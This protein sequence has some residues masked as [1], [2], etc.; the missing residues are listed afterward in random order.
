MVRLAPAGRHHAFEPLPHLSTKL[1]AHFPTACVHNFA[2]SDRPGQALFYHVVNAYGYS[3]LRKRTKERPGDQIEE[4]V[5]PVSTLDETLPNDQAVDLIKVD[6]EG[7]E[8]Q[9]FRGGRRTLA[10]CRPH[11]LFEHGIGG[12]NY[13]GTTPEMVYDF[14]VHELRYRIHAVDGSGPFSLAEFRATYQRNDRW[15]F[16]AQP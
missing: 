15:D 11:L 4:F 16:W 12:A 9:V 2:L 6:V 8:L 7:A 3:G 1:K 10:A 13:F 14:L 5:V